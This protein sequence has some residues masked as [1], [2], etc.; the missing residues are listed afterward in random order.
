MPKHLLSLPLHLP[1]HIVVDPLENVSAEAEELAA[2]LN[3]VVS[4]AEDV[5]DEVLLAPD[6][7]VDLGG[8]P[9]EAR[10]RL[11]LRL[12]GRVNLPRVLPQCQRCQ[13]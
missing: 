2:M 1:L 7:R 12:E 11:S 10:E 4:L 6:Q 13:E 5:A 9:A 8:L 3:Q